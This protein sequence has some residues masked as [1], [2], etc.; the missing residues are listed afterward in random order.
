[1]DTAI[2]HN[3][4]YVADTGTVYRVV[5]LETEVEAAGLP[6]SAG[7]SLV[8]HWTATTPAA[9]AETDDD[10]DDPFER[11]YATYGAPPADDGVR[12]TVTIPTD[13]GGVVDR[14]MRNISA[15]SGNP[16]ELF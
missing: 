2:E 10:D 16:G 8:R 5:D 4:T 13:N 7:D 9:A 12:A 3:G 11:S 6:E 1:M 15:A 14:L